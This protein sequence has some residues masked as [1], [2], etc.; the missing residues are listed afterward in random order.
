MRRRA[1]IAS[2]GL[3]GLAPLAALFAAPAAGPVPVTVPVVA[4]F[5]ILGDMVRQIGGT[6][7]SVTALVGPDEDAHIYNP[8]PKD[9]RALKAARLLV[10]NGLGLEGWMV[11]LTDSAGFTGMTVTATDKV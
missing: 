7:V 10:Q 5:S 9:L 3:T 6:A 4:S 1:F 8:R 2:L 11:R